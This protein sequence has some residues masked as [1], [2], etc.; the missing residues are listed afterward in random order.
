M[1]DSKQF[2]KAMG[3][4]ATGITIVSAKNKLTE[5]IRGVT[6]NAFMSLSL[7]PCL[8]SISLRENATMTD[9]LA[10]TN[11]FSISILA[12]E[13]RDYLMIFFNKKQIDEPVQF[14]TI[15]DTHVII[16]ALV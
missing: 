15:D 1:I 9:I 14:E 12:V 2:R 8:V 16:Y 13:Q 4:F 6:V 7:D 5:E 11:H 10:E 3:K